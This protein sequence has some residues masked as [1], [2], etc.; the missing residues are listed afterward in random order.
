[1][2]IAEGETLCEVLEDGTS[3]ACVIL[4]GDLD[5][6]RPGGRIHLVGTGK[7][8]VMS[9]SGAYCLHA[10]QDT[11]AL[12]GSLHS[13]TNCNPEPP[14]GPTP[15]RPG[16]GGVLAGVAVGGGMF[17][18]V[19]GLWVS[20]RFRAGHPTATFSDSSCAPRLLGL[21]MMAFP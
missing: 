19:L 20:L 13:E 8:A 10:N 7:V 3:Q 18:S 16:W 12:R 21:H 15:G 14:R 2:R 1:M 6:A 5:V 17:G 4:S 9:G 11:L